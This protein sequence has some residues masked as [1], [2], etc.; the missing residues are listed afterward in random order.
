MFIA[1]PT[2]SQ[3]IRRLEE[4]VGAPLLHRQRDGV[5]FTAAGTVLLEESRTVLSLLEH[6]V[7]SSRQAAGLERHRLRLVVHASLPEELVANVAIRL[8]SVATAADTDVTWLEGPLDT[9][10]T[11]VRTRQADSAL[12][13]LTSDPALLPDSQDAMVLGKFE[14]EVWLPEAVVGHQRVIGLD[15]LA[16]VDVVHGPRRTSPATYDAWVAR[17]RSIRSR[18]EFIEPPA[19]HSLPVALAFAATA[20]RPT[21]VL[22]SPLHAIGE[23]TADWWP[24]S[25]S[26]FD[27][28]RVRLSNC[29]LTATAALIWNG[30]LPRRLQQVLFDTADAAP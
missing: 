23:D 25:Q 6:G 16:A 10:F 14:P 30:D 7:R 29:P 20:D 3:Q 17:F 21:A 19:G 22:T 15:E 5:R 18:F 11:Q 27:M 12:G 24:P 9:G 1:Q 4:I 13:W 28:A 8:L 26:T 2:L